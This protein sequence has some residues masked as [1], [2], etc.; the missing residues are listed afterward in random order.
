MKKRL[1]TL[2]L[3]SLLS[4]APA[5][6][7][8]EQA[9]QAQQ[10]AQKTQN[11]QS[12]KVNDASQ[13]IEPTAQKPT[14]QTK[15]TI[16]DITTDYWAKMSIENVVSKDI[17]KLDDK[18]NFNPEKSLTRI[19]FVQALLKILSN[20]NLDVKISNIFTDV[21]ESDAYYADV[22]RSEQLGLVYGYPDNTF[23][24]NNTM[25]R[26]ETTSIISH[27][28][29]D[30]FVDCSILDTYTDKN[31]IPEWARIPYAKSIN[32][33]I[34][35]NHPDENKLEPNRNITRAEAAVLLSLLN[36]K[37]SL[38]KPKFVIPSE[39]MLSVEHLNLIRRTPCSKIQITN[40]RKIILEGNVIPV[41]YE[42]KFASKTT[43]E[44]DKVNFV[45]PE[46]LYTTEGTQLLPAGT[47]LTSEVLIVEPPKSFNRRAKVYVN[48]KQFVLPNGTAYDVQAKTYTRDNALKETL[49]LA[50]PKALTGVGAVMPGLNYRAKEGEKIK[51]IMLDDAF[52]TNPERMQQQE[53]QETG[54]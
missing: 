53:Q 34:F 40:W 32:Y 41:K 54:L 24:P 43:S 39:K 30:K 13:A 21:K 2:L 19:E 5:L 20:D 33:G 25:L 52:L 38:V 50:I 49:W 26:S 36:D 48:Y 8:N 51:V 6:A 45:L 15:V 29:K 1:A 27:I 3:L 42:S 23:L 11:V 18:G 28:T 37:L 7:E 35:V 47:K 22:L 31:D 14:E 46:G 12:I 16:N 9:G 10:P 17:M 4:I 44:G